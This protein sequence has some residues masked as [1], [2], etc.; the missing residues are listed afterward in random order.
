MVCLSGTN[1][2]WHESGTLGTLGGPLLNWHSH[3]VCKVYL[4]VLYDLINERQHGLH[5]L[6]CFF[7]A[8]VLIPGTNE[9]LTRSND[10]CGD[11]CNIENQSVDERPVESVGG[12]H[13]Q[14]VW[15]VDVENS[16]TTNV[17]WH[18]HHTNTR[19]IVPLLK[20]AQGP[21]TSTQILIRICLLT[22][23]III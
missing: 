3:G 16:S 20:L 12:F 13:N 9:K 6:T 19:G 8:V 7:V 5:H 15:E 21:L 14:L 23:K 18:E 17:V 2:V 11:C 1:V 22:I 10:N 4:T